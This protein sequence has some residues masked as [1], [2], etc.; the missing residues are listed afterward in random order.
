MIGINHPQDVFI[1][2]LNIIIM[3]VKKIYG[4]LKI[5]PT[6][7]KDKDNFSFIIEYCKSI[8][9]IFPENIIYSYRNSSFTSYNFRHI[10]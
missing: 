5:Q 6:A 3:R 10:L 7:R 9:T 2:S 1:K 8:I 4:N